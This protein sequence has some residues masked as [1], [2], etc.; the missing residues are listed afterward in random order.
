[1]E[2]AGEAQ[3]AW[4]RDYIRLVTN[5]LNTGQSVDE[6]LATTNT[7]TESPGGVPEGLEYA[8]SRS[9]DL[10]GD[11]ADEWLIG[12]PVPGM[13]C[14][15]TLC[16]SYV[17]LYEQVE[18]LFQPQYVIP[19]TPDIPTLSFADPR[20]IE[21]VNADGAT[22]V[23]IEQRSCG[24]HTCFTSFIVGRWDGTT[25]RDLTA[26]P[27][28]QSYA[29]TTIE[30]RDD[31]GAL[32]FTL[33]GGTSGSVGAGL[34]RQHTRIYDW[35]DGAYRLVQDIPDPSNHPYYLMLDA[36]RALTEEELTTALD[37][38]LQVVDDADFQSEAVENAMVPPEETN[39]ARIVGYAVIEAM[40]VY[41]Q[42]DDVAAMEDVLART[43]IRSW[44]EPNVYLEAA[45]Q[46]LSTYQQTEDPVQ[47]CAAMED[48][49]AGR[50]AEAVFF[51][52]YGYGTERITVDDL[53]PLDAPDEGESPY[54]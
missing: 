27:I 22:E 50:A 48:V 29:E 1:V 39:P 8:W 7:W 6:V 49:V 20:F 34:Q 33:H 40:L 44:I 4:T 15:A 21:D 32:E 9:T 2:T 12:L 45:E 23:V 28:S 19:G 53:C 31:D 14:G 10:D 26:E 3:Y 38:A 51:D 54:L 47:A 46:L 11:G 13:G 41:A 37:L 17:V 24:A 16:P 30:D 36:H 42:Q 35:Q 5:M 25:W 43:Q 18:G 52:W